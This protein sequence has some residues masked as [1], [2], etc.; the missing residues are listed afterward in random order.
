MV[1]AAL[2][3]CTVVGWLVVAQ[4][5]WLNPLL[6]VVRDAEDDV[7]LISHRPV[8]ELACAVRG[9]DGYTYDARA[10]RTWLRVCARE[11]R[12]SCVIPD[13]PI[14]VVRAVRI[15]PAPWARL[16]GATRS[17][18]RR[19]LRA[20]T[21]PYRPSRGHVA[22]RSVAT[23]TGHAPRRHRA[24]VQIPSVASAFSP[25]VRRRA[26]FCATPAP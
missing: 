22:C 8:S 5:C 21:H 19:R 9:D 18:V 25:F 11:G 10:L 3:R 6:P 24:A 1:T 7:C 23:Q 13:K 17:A 2:F 4:A 16:V 12:A 15:A 20:L 14:A 26:S